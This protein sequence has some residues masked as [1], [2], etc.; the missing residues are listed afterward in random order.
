MPARTEFKVEPTKFRLLFVSAVVLALGLIWSVYFAGIQFVDQSA[1]RAMKQQVQSETAILEDH[2]S[3]SLDVVTARLRFAAAFTNEEALR[4]GR[5]RTDRLYELIQEDRVVR[6]LSLVDDRG[7][8]V[9]S[10]NPRNLDALVPTGEFPDN[11]NGGVISNQVSY[12]NVFAYR[13]LG[14]I[15]SDTPTNSNL[16]FW[17]AS[18]PVSIKGRMYHWVAT[19]NLGLFE[20]LWNR[21]DE[22]PN[23]EIAIFN[24][25]GQRIAAHHGE[26]TAGVN[27]IGAEI[28][29]R[30]SRVEMGVF[31][32]VTAPHLVVAYRT[33]SEHPAI[34]AITGDTAK[35]LLARAPDRHQATLYAL[36]GTL[37]LLLV[38]AGLFRWYVSYEKSLNELANQI[39]ATGAHL[40]LS[41]SSRDGKILWANPLFLKTTG[42]A[43]DEI[44]GQNHRIFNSGLYPRSF[45]RE[46]WAQLGS[47]TIWSVTFRNRNKSGE[48]F[49]VKTTI[50]PFLD[51]WKKVSRYVALYT[52]ITEA[53]KISEQ[54]D[55]ER[56]LREEL[57]EKNRELA[58]NA[59][60]D[61]LTG[62]PN[63]RAYE[64]FRKTAVEQAMRLTQPISVLMLDLDKFKSIN[65]QYGHGAGDEVLRELTRRW[66]LQVRTSDMLARI[67]GEE[68]TVVLPQTTLAQAELVAEKFRE[69][70]ARTPVIIT[71]ADGKPMPLTITVSIGL[72]STDRIRGDEHMDRLM[73]LADE[74]L[75][76]AKSGGR[77]RVVAKRG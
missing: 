12:G 38:V 47:G 35:M 51:P 45:Y 18:I 54:I 17:L 77:N 62:V 55:H 72:S 15:A 9:A 23:T 46:L 26:I 28:V 75:Y 52:D 53:I 6:S 27:G 59:N 21:V 48:F 71:N 66:S 22:D 2:L 37:V 19:V 25:Q 7:R 76:P 42:Y 10:S 20:N 44:A 40:M 29:D 31:N 70:T 69:I 5:L 74:A 39:K 65:D 63:R 16:R 36:V 56:R 8:I 3:R 34:L 50:V 32:A 33:S 57:S 1:V 14:D 67:G 4:D 49:W 13:D 41:E 60:T 73:N 24:Y 11:L 68:F 43:L 58:V 64:E 61:S 30:V